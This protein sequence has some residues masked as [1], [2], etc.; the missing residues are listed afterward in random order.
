MIISKKYIKKFSNFLEP[1]YDFW[2]ALVFFV[3]VVECVC[4]RSGIV[5]GNIYIIFEKNWWLWYD[6]DADCK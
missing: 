5:F 2:Y 3:V 4:V 6:D 1:R